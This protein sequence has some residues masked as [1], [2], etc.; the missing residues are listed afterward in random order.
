MSARQGLSN[1]ASL[2]V[3]HVA[4]NPVVTGA[5]LWVL[6]KGPASV[7]DRLINSVSALRNPDTRARVTKLLRW[8]LALGV[9]RTV[10]TKLNQL[11]LNAYRTNSEKKR[12]KWNEEVAVVTGGCSGIGMLTVKRLLLKGVK[13]A[14]LDIQQLP[15]ALQGYAGISFFACDIADPGAVASTAE[16]V[17]ATMGSPS[18]LVNNAGITH[19]HTI[20]K[21]SPEYLRKIFD[22]NLLSNWYT[23]QAFLPD[24]IK[25]NKG[26][27]VTVASMASYWSVGGMV[28]Y[29]ATKAAVLCLHEGL[30]QEVRQKHE[31][32]NILFTSVHPN[33]VRTPLADPYAAKLKGVDLLEPAEVADAIAGQVL[34][35]AGG[36]IY[37]PS[38]AH[39]A[40]LVRGWPNWLQELLRT[41]LARTML[42]GTD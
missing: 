32:P 15:P 14:I 42:S 3:S 8:L 27:I 9:V 21:T 30:I 26:H 6:T 7:R 1:L 23:I 38:S 5:L 35:C 20:L 17:R 13:V 40:T 11:A 39:R 29:C 22:V 4:L 12:W 31:A 19:P 2:S 36:Q 10:N 41:R 28:D 37:L 33:F 25:K 16:K 24:M 18:I 34:G